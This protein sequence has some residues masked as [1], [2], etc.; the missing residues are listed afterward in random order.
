MSNNEA[1][2]VYSG[3]APDLHGLLAVLVLASATASVLLV[4]G[5]CRQAA[6]QAQRAWTRNRKKGVPLIWLIWSDLLRPPNS[7]APL[8][9]QQDLVLAGRL[10]AT[11]HSQRRLLA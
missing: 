3:W 2:D 4:R 7:T 6:D 10:P 9:L 8:P 1:A 5:R 11:Y